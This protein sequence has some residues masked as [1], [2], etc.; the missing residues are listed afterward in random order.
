MTGGFQFFVM[1][2]IVIPWVIGIFLISQ[3]SIYNGIME[4]RLRRRLKERRRREKEENLQ[5]YKIRMILKTVFRRDLSAGLFLSINIIF[6]FLSGLLAA[7]YYSLVTAIIAFFVA[8]ILPGIFVMIKLSEIRN[9]VSRDGE[10]FLGDYLANYRATNMDVLEAIARIGSKEQPKGS[11]E[12]YLLKVLFSVRNDSSAFNVR[13]ALNEFAFTV[14]THWARLFSYNLSIG[15]ISGEDISLA[16]EDVFIQLREGRALLE[17]RKR[18]NSE[19]ARIVLILI[20]LMYV[21]TVFVSV[22]FIG[23]EFKEFLSHQFKSSQGFS[24]FI[25]MT[26]IFIFNLLIMELVRS[27]P[28]DF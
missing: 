21:S 23:L 12:S 13:Q 5:L 14:N 3:N 17:R 18:L 20:P 27:Q 6:A 25:L 8:G 1:V 15:I 24:L 7:Y 4:I 22:N 19:A 26:G 2:L 10:S 16:L 28:L 11:L 9:K